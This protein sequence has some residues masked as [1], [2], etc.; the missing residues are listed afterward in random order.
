[1]E[2]SYYLDKDT[3]IDDNQLSCQPSNAAQGRGAFGRFRDTLG[4]HLYERQRWYGFQKNQQMHHILEWVEEEGIEPINA[5][6]PN[7]RF[8]IVDDRRNYRPPVLDHTR[9][10][11]IFIM[12]G[13]L[14]FDLERYLNSIPDWLIH[15]GCL[16]GKIGL[17]CA[18]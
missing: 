15:W 7:G 2:W 18:L 8:D 16:I 5:P 11:N 1:M 13:R 10:P 12:S 9:F 14:I 17:S 6:E 4:P 3:G